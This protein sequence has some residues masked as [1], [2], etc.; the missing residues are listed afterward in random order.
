MDARLS[1]L[2]TAGIAG[3]LVWLAFWG[4]VSP[5]PQGGGRPAIKQMIARSFTENDP[6]QCTEDMTPAFVSQTFGGHEDTAPMQRCLEQNTTEKEATAKSVTIKSVALNG[7]TARAVVVAH[8]G[9]MDGSEATVDLVL[10]GGRWK[11]ERLA[12]I[13]I[14]RASLDRM[15]LREMQA[16]GMSAGES[17]CLL[18]AF[19]REFSD[20]ELERATLSG[21]DNLENEGV[22]LGCLG[23]ST[24]VRMF[25]EGIARGV[26]SRGIPTPVADCIASRFTGGM[27]TAELRGFVKAGEGTPAQSERV[28]A[29]AA[30]CAADYRNGVLPRSGAA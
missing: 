15:Y 22:G 14:D 3:V 18:R 25:Q 10:Q 24:L 17:R 13:Q 30:A 12:D 26:Q 21:V 28:R 1:W 27:S 2:I 16:A 5:E 11:L 8:G 7:T 20:T 4:S 6:A 9:D 23:R 29:V 19:D